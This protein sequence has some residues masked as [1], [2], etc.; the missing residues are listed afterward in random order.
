MVKE[1]IEGQ[2]QDKKAMWVF[3]Y[4]HPRQK[5][6]YIAYPHKR[7]L[8]IF[9]EACRKVGIEEISLYQATRHSF[10][11]KK[12]RDGF[13]YEEVGAAMGHSSPQTTRRYARLRAENVKSV[14]EEDNILPFRRGKR[15]K[16]NRQ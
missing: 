11:L 5:N 13:S 4:R 10:A 8:A 16:K 15:R 12:L 2:A 7:L 3:P 14:F 9:K 1:I 6:L